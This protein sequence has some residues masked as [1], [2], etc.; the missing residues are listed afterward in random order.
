VSAG[1]LEALLDALHATGPGRLL[2]GVLARSR[3]L[4]AAAGALADTRASA[5]LVPWA[6]RTWGVDLADA[7]VPADG[8]PSF[9]AFFARGLRPGARAI[10]PDPFA[11]VSPA[12]G[13]ACARAPLGEGDRLPVKGASA[14]LAE[15][16]AD[17]AL[18]RAYRG[19]AAAIVRLYLPDCHRTHFPCDGTPG[20]PRSV[21]GT[22]HAMTPRA[23]NDV[24]WLA[25]NSRAVTLLETATFGRLVLVEGL[26]RHELALEE[27]LRAIERA[28]RLRQLGARAPHVGRVFGVGQ[29]LGIFGAVLR[30]RA[31]QRGLLLLKRVLLTFVVDL[32]EDLPRLHPIAEVGQDGAHRAFGFRRHRHLV[33]GSQGTN[34]VDRSTNGVAL[35]RHHRHLFGLTIGCSSPCGVGA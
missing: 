15:L 27:R 24:P 2:R 26:L 32:D 10:E 3:L 29:M 22:H 7:D 30:E 5:A 8:F 4:H 12:D 13:H 31:C 9:N 25:R 35:H 11:L 20:A 6:V 21:P 18:A 34:H 23:G 14:T 16:L 1:P 19:G 17:A 28:L 33:H